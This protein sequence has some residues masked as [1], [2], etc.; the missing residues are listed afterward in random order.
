MPTGVKSVLLVQRWPLSSLISELKV[1]QIEFK[2]NTKNSGF[3]LH[4]T[5][6]FPS[7][8]GFIRE[9]FTLTLSMKK[10]NLLDILLLTC[11]LHT[12]EQDRIFWLSLHTTREQLRQ[13]R[14]Q[15]YKDSRRNLFGLDV[16]LLAVRTGL[17]GRLAILTVKFVEGK[18]TQRW[19]EFL[20]L[21][22]QSSTQ[23]IVIAIP[24][25]GAETT[26]EQQINIGTFEAYW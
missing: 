4:L 8:V 25:S 7:L 18:G 23:S 26:M 6:L 5:Q 12:L 3:I 17:S 22:T 20:A 13:L 16:K 11:L 2:L 19:R 1:E 15:D 10:T 14:T 24:H 9:N 21:T